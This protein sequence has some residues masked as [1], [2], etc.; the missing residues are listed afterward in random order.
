MP[1]RVIN[2]DVS[3]HSLND[4]A[5]AYICKVK[6]TDKLPLLQIVLEASNQ[7]WDKA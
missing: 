4:H 1:H 7:T 3:A 2:Q 5:L 6:N